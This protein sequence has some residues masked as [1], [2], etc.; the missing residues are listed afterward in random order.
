M[1][2]TVKKTVVIA[3]AKYFFFLRRSFATYSSAVISTAY[4]ESAS[5]LSWLI[6]LDFAVKPDYVV[7]LMFED[8][9]TVEYFE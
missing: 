8:R 4:N 5:I 2:E 6:V 3:I 1:R 7:L 9:L